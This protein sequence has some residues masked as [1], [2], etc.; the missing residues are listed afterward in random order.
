MNER[1]KRGAVTNRETTASLLSKQTRRTSAQVQLDKNLL[2][3][4]S[5]AANVAKKSVTA[6][7]KSRVAAFEDQLRREDQQHEKNMG[8]PDLAHRVCDPLKTHLIYVATLKKS[9]PHMHRAAQ[10]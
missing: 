6:Q 7:K 8:R 4:A 5:A 3:S 1:P 2:A 9:C 10:A